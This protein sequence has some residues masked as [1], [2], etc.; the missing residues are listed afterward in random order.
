M[1]A[2]KKTIFLALQALGRSRKEIKEAD[3]KNNGF[4]S[5][6]LRAQNRRITK[7]LEKMHDESG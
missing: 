4:S 5:Y 1:K 6:L 3:T 2:Q 7:Q